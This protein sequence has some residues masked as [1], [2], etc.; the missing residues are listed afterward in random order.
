MHHVAEDLGRFRSSSNT[1][2]APFD[3]LNVLIKPAYRTASQRYSTK[4]REMV[5]IVSR[6]LKSVRRAEPHERGGVV[7]AF[8]L[9]K[10]KRVES[11]GADLAQ[12]ETGGSL[13]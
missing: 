4:M 3:D 5:H 7:G 6:A 8:S 12:N 1:D 10:K 11:D 2:A 9:K 13:E